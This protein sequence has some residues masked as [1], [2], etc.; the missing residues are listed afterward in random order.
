MSRLQPQ[1]WT[2]IIIDLNNLKGQSENLKKCHGIIPFLPQVLKIAL[3]FLWITLV[4]MQIVTY[5]KS[6]AI[7]VSNLMVQVDELRSK[8]LTSIRMFLTLQ[9][10]QNFIWNCAVFLV[11]FTSFSTY[12][13][14]ISAS[15]SVETTFV[16]LA[17]LNALR[18]SFRY[19]PYIT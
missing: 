6:L 3:F 17:L 8:E 1:Y 4:L 2:S 10:L 14:F 5:F 13:L 15:L 9:A 11:A 16:S 12:S 7:N 18:G 19:H